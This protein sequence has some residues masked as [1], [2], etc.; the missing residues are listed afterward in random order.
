MSATTKR[1]K[2][3]LFQSKEDQSRDWKKLGSPPSSQL[4]S[5]IW[6]S[7]WYPGWNQDKRIFFIKIYMLLLPWRSQNLLSLEVT[8]WEFFSPPPPSSKPQM[9]IILEPSLA[10]WDQSL[11]FIKRSMEIYLI[12]CLDSISG[13]VLLHLLR[14][15]FLFKRIFKRQYTCKIKF[16]K[17]QKSPA[18]PFLCCLYPLVTVVSNHLLHPFCEL[19]TWVLS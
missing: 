2:V 13:M 18:F 5:W 17:V 14:M 3:E 12:I 10:Q 19:Y 8:K 9:F 4:Q 15:T 1:S 16:Q 6:V 11:N 7:L